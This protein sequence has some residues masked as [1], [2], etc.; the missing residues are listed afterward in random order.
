VIEARFD[1]E[2][3]AVGRRERADPD[4]APALDHATEAISK[5]SAARAATASPTPAAQRRVVLSIA[6][7]GARAVIMVEDA[8]PGIAPDLRGGSSR[9][10]TRRSRIASVSGSPSRG[11]SRSLSGVTS[12]SARRSSAARWFASSSRRSAGHRRARRPERIREPD[13]LLLRQQA[14]TREAGRA[15]ALG[16]K[17]KSAGADAARPVTAGPRRFDAERARQ[18]MRAPTGEG[19]RGEDRAQRRGRR[20]SG[21]MTTASSSEASSASSS[22]GTYGPRARPRR[23]RR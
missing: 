3:Y 5:T 18:P 15:E 12:R 22:R 6:L 10:S 9:R 11:R 2:P 17:A 23:R 7:D 20:S 19:G 4:A 14:A 8:G 21:S 16:A 1:G 13:A